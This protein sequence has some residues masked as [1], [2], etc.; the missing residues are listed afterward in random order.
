H[1]GFRNMCESQAQVYNNHS[2]LRIL[3]FFSFSFDA[4][5]YEM[6]MALLSGATL[7]MA[8]RENL[9]PGTPLTRMICKYSI[10][11]MTL[12]P[13]VLAFLTPE[14]CPTLQ[15]VMV[16]GEACP[17]ELMVRWATG[18]RFLNGYGPTEATDWTTFW[19]CDAQ[20]EIVHIGRPIINT[21]LYI[22]DRHLQPTPVGV[23]G[24]IYVGGVGVGRGYLNRP[25]LTAEKFVPDPFGQVPGARLYKT[26]DLGH[27]VADGNVN[28]LGR[29]DHQVK[30]RGFRVELGEI[31][32]VLASHPGVQEAI[33]LVVENTRAEKSLIAYVIHKDASACTSETLRQFMLDRV[34]Y[35]MVPSNFIFLD[36][37][38]L[39]P[40]G[41]LDSKALPR[42]DGPR[43]SQKKFIAPRDLLE[44]ALVK[45]FEDV[46]KI[47][48]VGVTDNFFQDL[49][50]HSLLAVRLMTEIGKYLGTDINVSVLFQAPTIEELAY[51]LRRQTQAEQ[52]PLVEIQPVGH[53]TPLFCIHPGGGNIFCYL[54]LAHSL[55][56]GQRFYALQS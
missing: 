33:V 8:T 54:D 2:D 17:H 14:Q 30:I 56:S 3:Q 37:W 11:T 43:A 48:P 35:Y 53:S 7:F 47:Q 42:P 50:G 32:A 22:L 46:L 4:S 21:R 26:G 51:T 18:R 13:S 41:K 15:T 27:Y 12:T 10:T 5:L 36:S 28:F 16:G 31:E 9:Q 23:P 39:T 40:N 20:S 34:P 1:R 24:E 38:P 29:V 49:G 19:E 44:M 6:V 52:S 55:P 45:I 25:E